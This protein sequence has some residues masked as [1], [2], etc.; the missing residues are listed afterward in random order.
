MYVRPWTETAGGTL[1][2]VLHIKLMCCAATAA[3]LRQ[4]T[5]GGERQQQRQQQQQQPPLQSPSLLPFHSIIPRRACAGRRPEIE[6]V[7]VPF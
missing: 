3:N 7:H 1:A 2:E 6:S 4:H 5:P